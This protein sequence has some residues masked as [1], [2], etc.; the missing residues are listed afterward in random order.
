MNDLEPPSYSARSVDI[1]V[2]GPISGRSGT[3]LSSRVCER[4]RIKISE[5]H[6]ETGNDERSAVDATNLIEIV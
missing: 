3:A 4:W 5:L 1:D 2:S 6:H